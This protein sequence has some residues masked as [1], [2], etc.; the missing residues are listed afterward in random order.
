MLKKVAV[1]GIEFVVEDAGSGAPVLLIHGFPLTHDMWAEQIQFLSQSHRVIA[2]DLRGFG[3]SQVVD[4]PATMETYADDLAAICEAL[5]VNEPL[6]VCGFSMGGYILFEFWRK[7]KDKVRSLVLC[8]TRT[9]ADTPEGANDRLK[10]AD[11]VVASGNEQL[12]IGM[13]EKL[14]SPA[15]IS[16]Y[17]ALVQHTAAMMRA[18]SPTGIAVALRAM[19]GRADSTYL[20]AEIDVP[21]KVIVG[22]DDVISTPAEMRGIAQAVPQAEFITIPVAGHLTPIENHSA[23]NSVLI[24]VSS[25]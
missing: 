5:E 6:A 23:V 4:S 7:Y 12:V 22:E 17:P 15:T 24:R 14:F 20:L 11:R 25:C 21:V 18:N 10:M 1:N 3:G 2:P 9:V 16:G 19:A 13:V 8:D